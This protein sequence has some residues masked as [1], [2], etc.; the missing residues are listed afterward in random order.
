MTAPGRLGIIGGMTWRASAEYYR[1]ANE[2]VAARSGAPHSADLTMVSLDFAPLVRGL[3]EG[4]PDEVGATLVDAA[5]RLERT[6]PA[7]LVLAANTAHLWFDQVSAAV[8][9]PVVHVADGVHRAAQ[10]AG[11]SR[12]GV[13]GTT[14]TA[15]AEVYAHGRG[16]GTRLVLPST[17]AQDALHRLITVDLAARGPRPDDAELLATIGA[18]LVA[19]GADAVVLGCTEFSGIGLPLD[20]PVLDSTALHVRAALE[21]AA[22]LDAHTA[23]SVVDSASTH[24]PACDRTPLRSSTGP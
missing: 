16:D 2:L 12:L 11:A 14:A 17:E 3:T 13:L 15:R 21:R 22:D 23:R 18:D 1:I 5:R 6:A 9:C 24:A 10:E 4:R 20:V 7:V 8:G 19:S